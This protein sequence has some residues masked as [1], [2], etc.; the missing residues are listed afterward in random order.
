M[1]S[2]STQQTRPSLL[3]RVRDHDDVDAWR[4]FVEAYTPLIVCFA[5]KRGFQEADA[6]DLAQEV[7]QKVVY[8]ISRFDYD[9][10]RG[11]FRS[12]LYRITRNALSDHV[13]TA[14]RQVQGTGDDRHQELLKLAHGDDEL[15]QHWDREH[16]A[17]MMRWAMGKLR[18]DFSSSTISAFER[19]VLGEEKVAVVAKDLGLSVGAVYIAKSRALVRLR[20]ILHEVESPGLGGLPE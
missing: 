5:M 12:W 15:E 10:E 13:E 17:H 8:G 20:E 7:M 14:K 2:V 3:V 16:A 9:P 1:G 19:T 4:E 18:A 6:A 11:T